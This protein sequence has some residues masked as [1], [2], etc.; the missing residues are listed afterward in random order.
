MINWNEAEMDQRQELMG[1]MTELEMTSP[2]KFLAMF[3]V[4][5]AMMG[6]CDVAMPE[7]YSRGVFK[8]AIRVLRMTQ[9]RNQEL[10]PDIELAVTLIR[11][12]WL[13]RQDNK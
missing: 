12:K 11:Q 3:A 10:V 9:R 7:G 1:R 5:H 4:L 8:K 13:H 2:E 6:D